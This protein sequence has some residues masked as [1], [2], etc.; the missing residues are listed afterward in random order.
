MDL[1]TAAATM[2]GNVRVGLENSLFISR[3]QLAESNAQQVS[4]IRRML[5]EHALE[6]REMLGLKRQENTKF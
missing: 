3:G 6:A 1:A 5:A 2:G 4:K